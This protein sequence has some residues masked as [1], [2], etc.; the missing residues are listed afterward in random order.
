MRLAALLA[1]AR[2]RAFTRFFAP[3][4]L[5]VDGFAIYVIASMNGL[6]G[7]MSETRA[8]EPTAEKGAGKRHGGVGAGGAGGT[9]SGSEEDGP[10]RGVG[11]QFA[12]LLF[13]NDG[14]DDR[15]EKKAEA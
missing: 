2:M 13:G 8:Q 15:G 4:R 9:E 14:L 3:V 11:K 1:N 10:G 12:E 7:R 6:N 5:G